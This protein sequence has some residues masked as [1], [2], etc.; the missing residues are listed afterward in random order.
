MMVGWQ[1]DLILQRCQKNKNVFEYKQS[2]QD[3]KHP[4]LSA[5]SLA[6]A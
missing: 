4:K 5:Q 2:L 3:Y 1:D 6:S